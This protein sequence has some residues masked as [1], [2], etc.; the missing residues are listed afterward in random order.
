LLVG[1]L[2]AAAVST[3]V[4]ATACIVPVAVAP[5]AHAS[6]CNDFSRLVSQDITT[7]SWGYIGYAEMVY[8]PSCRQVQAHFHLDSSFY[9]GG[10]SGWNTWARV[11]YEDPSGYVSSTDSTWLNT[12][13][14]DFW[15]PVTSIYGHGSSNLDVTADWQYNACKIWLE[16]P[17]WNFNNGSIYESGSVGVF[18]GYS[19]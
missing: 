7:A 11:A 1:R 12:S 14:Q 18:P 2:K 4:A 16:T 13:G 17:T 5:A 19:C 3:V 6:G 15:T 8:S 10:H 9:F